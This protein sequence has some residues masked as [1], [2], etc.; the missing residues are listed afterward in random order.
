MGHWGLLDEHFF[1][2]RLTDQ[3]APKSLSLILKIEG[4]MHALQGRIQAGADPAYAPPKS[5]T[6]AIFGTIFF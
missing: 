2:F 1:M 6:N 5:P 4:Q 3:P